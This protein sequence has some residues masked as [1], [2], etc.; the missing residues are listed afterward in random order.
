MLFTFK[1]A[2]HLRID[3]IA[4]VILITIKMVPGQYKQNL[5]RWRRAGGCDRCRRDERKCRGAAVAGRPITTGGFVRRGQ[6]Q[7]HPRYRGES[8]ASED[9]RAK[10]VGS[11]TSRMHP[12]AAAY[13]KGS[14]TQSGKLRQKSKLEWRQ[15]NCIFQWPGEN[16]LASYKVKRSRRL[17]Q[18]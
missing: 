13:I 6:D 8:A 10:V 1:T 11:Q 4:D 7:G 17:Y 16:I 15:N 18:R 3:L 14:I 9:S 12:L 5:F 2:I